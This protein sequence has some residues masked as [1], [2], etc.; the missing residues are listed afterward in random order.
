MDIPDV[1]F[2]WLILFGNA[3]SKDLNYNAW[4]NRSLLHYTNNE[5]GMF[6]LKHNDNDGEVDVYCTYETFAKKVNSNATYIPGL[7]LGILVAYEK[8][9]RG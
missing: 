2:L 8:S 7:K 9:V 1:L 3:K 6:I 5:G 4:N